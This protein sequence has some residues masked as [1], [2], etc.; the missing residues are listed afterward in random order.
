MDY[1]EFKLWK[2]AALAVAAFIIAFVIE[3]NRHK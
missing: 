1:L 2:L 3:F